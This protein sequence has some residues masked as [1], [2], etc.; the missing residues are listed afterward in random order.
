VS[1]K[2]RYVLMVVLSPDASWAVGITKKKGPS[3]LH[4]RIC[5]PGGKIDG[6][7]TPLTAASREMQEETGLVIPE[8]E[9]TPL[10]KVASEGYDLHVFAACSDKVLH[11]R[12]LE[13][14]PV[15]H[16]NVSSHEVFAKNQPAQYAPDF[17]DDLGAAVHALRLRQMPAAA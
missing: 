5:F 7:E 10:R 12:Q 15:W 4:G 9:W 17:L 3:F 14:E 1:E 16:L 2:Q 11:A 13:E 6:D 8:S